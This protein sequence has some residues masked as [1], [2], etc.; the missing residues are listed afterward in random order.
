PAR[1]THTETAR[2]QLAAAARAAFTGGNTRSS[3]NEVTVMTTDLITT[4]ADD[5]WG[6]VAA[7]ANER[8]LAAPCSNLPT[9]IGPAAKKPSRSSAARRWSRSAPRRHGHYGGTASRWNT[10]CARPERRCRNARSLA[11][12]IK[13]NGKSDRTTSRGIRGGIQDSSTWSIR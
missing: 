1:P 11:I 13:R 3:H 9:R 2:A 10:G 4:I 5:G 8:V 12:S 7:E 6:D